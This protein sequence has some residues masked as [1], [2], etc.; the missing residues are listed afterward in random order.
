M[1]E[2]IDPRVAAVLHQAQLLQAVMD[3]QLHK[4]STETFTATDD[5]GTV[6]VKVTLNAEQHLVDVHIENGLLRRL[7]AATIQQRLNH[8]LRNASATATAAM[9]AD[10]QRLDTIVTLLPTTCPSPN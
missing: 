4:M 5:T 1:T 3:T 10:Q 6:T 2:Q 9:L 7:G 8:A